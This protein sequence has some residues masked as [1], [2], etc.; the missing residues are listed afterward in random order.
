MYKVKYWKKS[1]V[2][3]WPPERTCRVRS[4]W[5][6]QLRDG[7]ARLRVLCPGCNSAISLAGFPVPSERRT[8]LAV[9]PLSFF[10]T[11]SKAQKLHLTLV[12][13]VPYRNLRK[14]EQGYEEEAR[15]GSIGW[16]L[17]AARDREVTDWNLGRVEFRLLITSKA[18]VGCFDLNQRE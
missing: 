10:Q 9:E 2:Q 4:P 16:V 14:R 8:H 17:G 1:R 13:L 7:T 6:S 12:R 15:S 3:H 11:N 18:V 5:F